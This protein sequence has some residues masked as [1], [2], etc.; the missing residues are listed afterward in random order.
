M[1][2]RSGCR[3]LAVCHCRTVAFVQLLMSPR[4]S[5]KLLA[6]MLLTVSLITFALPSNRGAAQSAN[7]TH[8]IR[9]WNESG[10]ATV[11]ITLNLPNDFVRTNGVTTINVGCGEVRSCH[12]GYLRVSGTAST[13]VTGSFSML[14]P[15]DEYGLSITAILSSA[16]LGRIEHRFSNYSLSLPKPKLIDMEHVETEISEL[17][18]DG[19][20]DLVIKYF[21]R[22]T[23]EWPVT[24]FRA[25]AKCIEEPDCSSIKTV[26]PGW[27]DDPVGTPHGVYFELNGIVP[28]ERRLKVTFESINPVPSE[29][30]EAKSIEDLSVSIP[31]AKPP[32]VSFAG[33]EIVEY[34]E[35]GTATVQFEFDIERADAWPITSISSKLGCLDRSCGFGGLIERISFN[36]SSKSVIRWETIAPG[37]KPGKTRLGA[38]FSAIHSPWIGADRSAV[39]TEI[40]IEIEPQPEFKVVWDSDAD[41]VGYFMSGEAHVNLELSPRQLGFAGPSDETLQGLCFEVEGNDRSCAR[42]SAPTEFSVGRDR[43]KVKLPR[44]RQ[45][46]NMVSIDAGRASGVVS[47]EVP[48]RTVGVPREVW[49][50]FVDSGRGRVQPCAGLETQRVRKW[51]R[52]TLNVYREGDPL[53]VKFFDEALDHVETI[54]GIDYEIVE[55]IDDADVEAYLAHRGSPRIRELFDSHCNVF[56]PCARH[57]FADSLS[58]T[59]A[60]GYVLVDHVFGG[61]PLEKDALEKFVRYEVGLAATQLLVPHASG[62]FDRSAHRGEPPFYTSVVDFKVLPLLYLPQV[63]PG[64]R[65][66]DIREFVVFADETLDYVPSLPDIELVGYHLWRELM[67]ARSVALE[68]RGADVR[69]DTREFGPIIDVQFSDIHPFTHRLVKFSTPDLDALILGFVDEETWVFDDSNW[70]LESVSPGFTSVY[71]QDIKFEPSLVTPIQFLAD[72]RKYPDGFELR[73]LES[74]LMSLTREVGRYPRGDYD[75]EIIFDPESYRVQ[76]YR[77][78]WYFDEDVRP[79]YEVEAWDVEYGE[80]DFEMPEGIR[81]NSAYYDRFLR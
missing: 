69:E 46:L 25:S 42:A 72:T 78:K 65:R 57:E 27:N 53:Y 34:S 56:R 64:M 49:K 4:L 32:N 28:G 24:Y 79:P 5:T 21:A 29:H 58:F 33:Y 6:L 7:I 43:V 19:T 23:G 10:I 16:R 80:G 62:S 2:D 41:V 76:S 61:L 35:D 44:L 63:K 1:V 17:N 14:L 77:L 18:D 11:W 70:V 75:A 59:V 15:P 37:F 22:R 8:E 20:V 30:V 74:D 60:K 81:E 52:A 26:R 50:C 31:V 36:D 67:D 66:E 71:R 40:T 12:R 73:R 45:G 3:P 48:V 47:V 68:A 54:T 39:I 9:S 13:G 38:T 55:S 51:D